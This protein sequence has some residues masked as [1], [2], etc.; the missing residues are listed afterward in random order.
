MTEGRQFK[1]PSFDDGQAGRVIASLAVAVMIDQMYLMLYNLIFTSLPPMAVGVLDRDAPSDVLSSRPGLYVRG[2]AE[3]VYT[4]HS[5]WVNIADAL[6]QVG[7]LFT[8]LF[9]LF[10][11]SPFSA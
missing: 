6:Y 8:N 11:L 10:E 5:F 2:R 3:Q 1:G 4:K 7:S 9:G